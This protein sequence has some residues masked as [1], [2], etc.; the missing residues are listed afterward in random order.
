MRYSGNHA[1]IVA[2]DFDGTITTTKTLHDFDMDL[3]PRDNCHRTLQT[4]HKAGCQLI[5]WTC[6]EGEHLQQAIDYLRKW[7]LPIYR[8]NENVEN[9]DWECR[10]VYADY[11]V[12]DLAYDKEDINW[13][14]V[15]RNITKH[16]YFH[17]SEGV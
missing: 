16:P 1:P 10:K 13:F 8:Y 2:V 15:W 14:H 5:L 17:K 7:D 3:P 6:R 12:D 11:Y 4:L 9:L